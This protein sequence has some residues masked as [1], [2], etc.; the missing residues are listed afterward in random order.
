[1]S[2]QDFLLASEPLCQGN[3]SLPYPKET[4]ERLLIKK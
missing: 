4:E 1:M 2:N 3:A